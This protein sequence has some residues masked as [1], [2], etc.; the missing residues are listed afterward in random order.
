MSGGQIAWLAVLIMLLGGCASSGSY[1]PAKKYAP[2]ALMSDARVARQTLEDC[3]PALTWYEPAEKVALAFDGL[4]G[5]LTDS[6][7]EAQ[8][9][10]RMAKALATIRCGHTSVRPSRAA[11]KYARKHPPREPV[12]PLQVK[13]WGGDSMV[14]LANAHRADSVL[15]RGTT[16]QT[17]QG[18]TIAQ[19]LDTLCQ[20]ISTDGYHRNFA[21]QLISNN[22][23]AWY[24][25]VFGLAGE[26]RIGYTHLSG[27]SGT[28]VIKDFDPRGADS[29]R[30][31]SQARRPPVPD[32]L[33]SSPPPRTATGRFTIDTARSLAIMDINSFSTSGQQRF[34]R[35]SFAT[36][37]RLGIQHLVLELREN[38]G[39]KIN[40]STK[41]T[42]YLASQPFRVADTVAAKSLKY[43]YPGRL[44]E[45]LLYKVQALFVTRRMADG[46]LHYRRYETKYFQPLKKHHFNGKVFIITGGFT[47][48]ASNLFITPLKGQ[49]NVTIV[50]EETGGGAYGNSAINIPELVLPNTRVR[51]RLPLYRMVI[52]SKAPHDGRGIQPDVA[53]PPGSRYLSN[54]QDPKMLKVYELIGKGKEENGNRNL[55]K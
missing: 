53:V 12:F 40:N 11:S 19:I 5:G 7:T 32:S 45:G 54:R 16:I 42:R 43:P 48:S 9:R 44:R 37:H 15:V 26:Y 21:W 39:G 24:K 46:Q 3:H 14:V 22:F 17:I 6:L 41:L 51:M 13:V 31:Q 28:A 47:F 25:S 20:Y 10:L 55:Q 18:R 38:G 2:E 4:Q 23:P 34:F 29:G 52:N 27:A 30:R 50:G 36:L 33:R 35:K 1:K 49:P 8:F